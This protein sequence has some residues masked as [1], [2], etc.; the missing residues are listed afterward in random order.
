MTSPPGRTPIG[1]RW[2]FGVA[3]IGASVAA[4]AAQAASGDK[5]KLNAQ[6]TIDKSVL[7]DLTDGRYW[8]IEQSGGG[9][10]DSWDWQISSESWGC[11]LV[12]PTP[13]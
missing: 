2:A 3:G 1:G 6:Q 4:A 5:L 7:L 13:N 11:A 9:F 8:T 10:L 12:K